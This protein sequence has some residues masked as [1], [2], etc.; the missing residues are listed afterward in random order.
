MVPDKVL[1]FAV[2]I[3]QFQVESRM[4]L[5]QLVFEYVSLKVLSLSALVLLSK[6]GHTTS[7]DTEMIVSL[8]AVIGEIM[9]IVE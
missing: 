7:Y 9:H 1:V 2:V 8:F 3:E 5:A 4:L 6:P